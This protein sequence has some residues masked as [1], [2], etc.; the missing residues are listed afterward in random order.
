MMQVEFERLMG[1]SEE[2]LRVMGDYDRERNFKEAEGCYML[3]RNVWKQ[4]FTQLVRLHG[5][6]LQ[7]GGGQ[8]RRR[9]WHSKTF[10]CLRATV[11]TMLH[12]N[13]VSQGMA[14]ELVGHDSPEVH[15][16]YLRPSADQLREAAERLT[17]MGA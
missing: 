1:Y 6:G 4:E 14:M 12:A 13:G 16:V 9:T 3:L 17:L 10:H 15:A 8:G 2:E 7:N 11:V 5:I